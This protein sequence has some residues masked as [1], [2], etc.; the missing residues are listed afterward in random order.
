MNCKHCGKPLTKDDHGTLIDNTGGD[1]CGT[2]GTFGNEPHITDQP[3][4]PAIPT[5]EHPMNAQEIE[6][7]K[8]FEKGLNKGDKVRICWTNSGSVYRAEAEVYK[9]NRE[10]IIAEL[11]EVVKHTCGSNYK[12]GQRIK[13]PRLTIGSGGD[14]WSN[15]NRVEPLGGY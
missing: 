10:S 5:R 7:V 6:T 9:V 1:V 12:I 15:N 8:T 4:L 14:L 2:Y 13:A 3:E 11:T